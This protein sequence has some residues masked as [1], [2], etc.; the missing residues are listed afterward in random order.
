MVG[1][2]FCFRPLVFLI[3]LVFDFLTSRIF[4]CSNLVFSHSTCSVKTVLCNVITGSI[5]RV[6]CYEL[7]KL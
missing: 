6:N 7:S 3:V 1:L 4:Y 5:E 2:F